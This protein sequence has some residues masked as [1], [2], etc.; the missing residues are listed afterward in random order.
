MATCQF[1]GELRLMF[2]WFELGVHIVTFRKVKRYFRQTISA[3]LRPSKNSSFMS[4]QVSEEGG[5]KVK[6][7]KTRVWLG[8]VGAFAL[9]FRYIDQD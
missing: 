5:S 1:E 7:Y 2:D 8:V 9:H 3:C 4:S 6:V